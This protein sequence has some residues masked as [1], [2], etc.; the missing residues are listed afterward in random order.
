LETSGYV[1]RKYGKNEKVT[2]SPD[3]QAGFQLAS[4]YWEGENCRSL[5]FARD[6]KGEGG[7]LIGYVVLTASI[8]RLFIAPLTC[9]RK[10]AS[11]T[12]PMNSILMR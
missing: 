9:P 1:F 12:L 6:D 5:G 4:D 11:Q 7:A 10:G 2:G 8:G 3:E